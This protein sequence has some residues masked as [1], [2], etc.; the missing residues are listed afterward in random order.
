M[1]PGGPF[2]DEEGEEEQR[3]VEEWSINPRE[4]EE[5]GPSESR[6]DW[7]RLASRSEWV[8]LTNRNQ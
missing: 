3:R 2:Q 4:G 8:F 5:E 6:G 7:G 1:E